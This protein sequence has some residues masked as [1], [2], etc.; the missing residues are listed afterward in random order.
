MR[1]FQAVADEAGFSAA[2]RQLDL[3]VPTVTR[4]V[5]DLER[6]L[7]TRLL[8]RTTRSVTL[9]EAGEAYLERVRVILADVDQAF[10]LAQ[11][12]TQEVAGIV[13]LFSPSVFAE[14]VL[15]PLLSE[16]HQRYPHVSIELIVGIAEDTAAGEY[17]IALL[18][19]KEI[20]DAS[21]VARP[22]ITTCGLVCASPGYLARN[23]EPRLPADLEQHQ[24]L[25]RHRSRDRA[26]VLRMQHTDGSEAEVRIK[27][28]MTANHAG[29]LLRAALDGAGIC[30]QP[31]ELVAR[32]M[33]QGLL[34]QV[35]PGWST[36]RFTLYAT[37]PTRKY[38]PV[39]VRHFLDFLTER[40]TQSWQAQGDG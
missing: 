24:C 33:H 37:Y 25:I 15:A 10:D 39:R 7:S 31:L 14:H 30:I 1:A 8:Q 16:F 4:L 27:P 20:F 26:D 21:V 35:L 17:D 32:Y 12:H 11:S 23:G 29:I 18:G 38:M 3:S 40:T 5:A 19:G 2:A 13:R 28:L 34:R 36:E 9:T 6:H 22:L